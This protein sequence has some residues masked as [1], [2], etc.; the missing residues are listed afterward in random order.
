[1]LDGFKQVNERLGH[2]IG[3]RVITRVGFRLRTA[4]PDHFLARF[5]GDEFAMIVDGDDTEKLLEIVGRLIEAV[6][7]PAQFGESVA[8]VGL[9]AGMAIRGVH[10]N[11]ADA[12]MRAAD[13]ALLSAKRRHGSNAVMFDASQA[14]AAAARAALESSVEAA[15]RSGS[16]EMMFQP[17]INA[18]R[19]SLMALELR[20]MV[21]SD[22]G[23]IDAEQVLQIITQRGRSEGLH[24]L[25]LPAALSTVAS[26]PA[27][28][29]LWY[30]VV[31]ADLANPAFAVQV[32]AQLAAHNLA[33]SR[34]I[35]AVA[36]AD[37]MT[38]EPGNAEVIR[39]LR[40]QGVRLAIDDFGDGVSHL[41]RLSHFPIDI[42]ALGP[43]LLSSL[44]HDPAVAG[45]V[46]GAAGVGR[47][48]D[49]QVV[50][51][52]VASADIMTALRDIGVTLVAGDFLSPPVAGDRTAAAV[53][54][55]LASLGGGQSRPL[56]N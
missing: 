27:P 11:T 29:A 31:E 37:L 50:A 5:G 7:T 23:M 22:S 52:G 32:L 15:L 24:K 45:I 9:A 48:L 1:D 44:A 46:A 14:E 35:L 30:H 55:A 18:Q 49:M 56:L 43:T 41:S 12:L 8:Q 2:P 13:L 42:I 39:Q 34:L 16:I 38:V 17:V 28:V 33:P 54:V 3:D 6:D 53:S 21:R 19:G 40:K 20:P 36:E 10:G 26:H 51:K 4:A 47:A 25:A